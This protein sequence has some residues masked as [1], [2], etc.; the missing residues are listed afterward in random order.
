M[1]TTERGVAG[2]EIENKTKVGA[3]IILGRSP[4]TDENT[5]NRMQKALSH[6]VTLCKKMKE[7]EKEPF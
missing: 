3:D 2:E 1:V 4:T 6:A 5:A 7:K